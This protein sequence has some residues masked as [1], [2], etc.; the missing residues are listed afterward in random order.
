MKKTNLLIIIVLTVASILIAVGAYFWATGMIDSNY[1]YRSPIKDTA[2]SP[3]TALGEPA[4]GRMVLVLIDALRYDTSLKTDV[5]PTLAALR[6]QGASALMHS[7]PPSFSEP[8]YSTLLTGAWPDI[9]DGPVFN[10]DYEDIPTFTQDNLFSAAKRIG[11]STAVSGYYWFEKL[12]P[13][14]DV[15]FSFYTPGE[16]AAADREVVDAALPWLKM[17]RLNLSSST[18]TRWIMPDIM[19]EDL[20]LRIGTK[21]RRGQ[22]PFWLRSWQN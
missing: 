17:T 20:F 1:A 4:S 7:R 13:Q 15:D 10:L 11:L 14:V 19:K 12:I 16:D 18:L 5:M 8:G 3:G 22:M 21:L 6:Q 9:N 2:P